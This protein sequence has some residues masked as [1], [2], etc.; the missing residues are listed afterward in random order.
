VT[1][2]YNKAN[3]Y[4]AS[5]TFQWPAG[6]TRVTV[7]ATPIGLWANGHGP[8]TSETSD[9]IFRPDDCEL[10]KVSTKVA[11]VGTSLSGYGVVD[12][13]F[14]NSSTSPLAD[15]VSFT[16]PA[17]NGSPAVSFDVDKGQIVVKTYQPIA[18]GTYTVAITSDTIPFSQTQTF[19]VDCNHA[20]PVVTS[21]AS[22]DEESNDG[23][24]TITLSNLLGA[25]TATFI[26]ANPFTSALENIDVPAG[27]STTRSFSGFTDGTHTV[28][29]SVVGSNTNFDQTFIVKCDLAPKVSVSEA[30]VEFNG[31]LSVLLENFGDDVAI[32]FTVNNV[33]HIVDPND[34][35]T[36]II[37]GLADGPYSIP[38]SINGVAQP[39]LTGTIHCDPEFG[40]QAVCNTVDTEGAVSL[41]WFTINNTENTDLLV[42][43]TGGSAT[44]PAKG[45]KTIA[46]TTAPLSL[47]YNGGVI[48]T[49]PATQVI[50]TRDITFTKVLVGQPPTG[51]TY[52]IRVSRLGGGAV[53]EEE[54]TF[55]LKAG[56]PVT[57]SLPST[58]DPA[59]LDYKFE[60]IDAGSAASSS[61]SPDQLKLSGN[62]GETISV[63]VTNNY[64][65]V[66]IVKQSLT[67]SVQAGGQITYTLQAT[68]TGGLALDPVV[69]TDRL[70]PQVSFVT[71]TVA[72]NGGVCALAES[73]RPQLLSCTMFGTL[74]PG[75]L[76]KTITLT[77][78]VDSNV[79]AGTQIL[80]QAKVLGAY[81]NVVL[82]PA[83]AATD[84]S[85]LPAIAGT[86]CDLSA[87]V[88]VPVSEVGQE[89][90][91]TT[92][93]VTKQLPS[94]GSST[95]LPT[96]ALALGFAGL[97]G[98]LLISRRRTA[99]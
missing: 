23:T 82:A 72:D 88:A 91:T 18:D 34:S 51:E 93:T 64:A 21:S 41:Y 15:G 99:R 78:K 79:V 5:G 66:Q 96:L 29:V 42:T 92:T 25:E 13:T 43:W 54:V 74:A 70:A 49:A 63:V 62:L 61:M 83:A 38:L 53:Y 60:E 24:V 33:D 59:G 73:T 8:G 52:T 3:G 16:I 37:G 55:D 39:A 17:F 28:A 40:V 98:I 85:C 47:K 1:V 36:V 35:L 12:F 90:P 32:K 68:N 67:T 26:V 57:I 81:T 86:V 10:Q 58:L 9:T 50:C 84:L 97:G 65:S 22:C 7:T 77:V 80:N 89:A 45:S 31:S 6:A 2:Q 19:T 30:C 27:G 56:V 94:T 95:T 87:T 46:S 48:A 76:T 11:C 69:I 14:D 71:A 4:T 75:A 44:V 20:A